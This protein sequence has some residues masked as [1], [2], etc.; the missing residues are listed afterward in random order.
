[1]GARAGDTFQSGGSGAVLLDLIERENGKSKS[2]ASLTHTAAAP[3][4]KC[5]FMIIPWEKL[6]KVS[7]DH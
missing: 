2:E 5:L 7:H 3:K 4:R 1:M 6:N